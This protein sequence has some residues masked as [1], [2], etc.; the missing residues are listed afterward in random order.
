MGRQE[1]T[2]QYYKIRYIGKDDSKQQLRNREHNTRR[3]QEDN[4][5]VE[6]GLKPMY[7]KTL[8]T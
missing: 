8:N 2:K 1:G 6:Q 7:T 4:R 5:K 3:S